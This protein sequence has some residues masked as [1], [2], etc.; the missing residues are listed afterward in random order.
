M[1][2]R[3]GTTRRFTSTAQ[4]ACDRSNRRTKSATVV[5][6]GTS[7]DSPLTLTVIT[8]NDRPMLARITMVATLAMLAMQS[9]CADPLY[10][11][12]TPQKTVDAAKQMVVDG[13]PDLLP[14]LIHL[15]P[16]DITY[17]DGVTEAS[18]IGDVQGKAGEM[19]AQLWRVATKLRDRYP[20]EVKKDLAIAVGAGRARDEQFGRL[21]RR[22][23]TDPQG[24]VEEQSARFQVEDLED[25]TASVSVDDA[26]AFGGTLSMIET[27]DG[28]RFTIPVDLA[29][30]SGY[31]P[32]TR[33]EWAVIASMMLGVEN[34][35]KEFE[36]EIDDDKFPTLRQASERAGRV[37]GESVV[38]QSVIY[39]YMKR[40]KTGGGS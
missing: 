16:R 3:F 18:A 8:A 12:S 27:S 39:A 31:W 25:G 33:H 19:L 35:L 9:G 23:L 37:V 22:F 29:R 11:T 32:D 30:T 17:D 13:R 2:S 10:D 7:C 1:W 6:S 21:L 40:P 24:L 26:P 38:V 28:W 14:T 34:A 5:P 36:D 20:A 15:K 4:A